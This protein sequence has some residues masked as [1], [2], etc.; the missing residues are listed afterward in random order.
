[1]SLFLER[2]RDTPK[3]RTRVGL[4]PI[5]V[6]SVGVFQ[7]DTSHT[8]CR[9]RDKNKNNASLCHLAICVFLYQVKTL[10]SSSFVTWVRVIVLLVVR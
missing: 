2:A 6:L 8:S 5:L 7:A 9:D 1:M 3:D 4:R 10:R